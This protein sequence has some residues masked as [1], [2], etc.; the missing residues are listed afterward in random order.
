MGEKSIGEGVSGRVI[1]EWVMGEGALGT[2][3]TKWNR[4]SHHEGTHGA[5]T[6]CKVNSWGPM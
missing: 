6:L 1:K 4:K 3:A 2:G 5:R